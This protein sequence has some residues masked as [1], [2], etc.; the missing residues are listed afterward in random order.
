MIIREWGDKHKQ[1]FLNLTMISSDLGRPQEDFALF[2]EMS[3][4]GGEV[5]KDD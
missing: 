1:M 5:Y 3:D 4:L 2:L